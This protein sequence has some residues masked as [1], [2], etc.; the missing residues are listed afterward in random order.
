V[1]DRGFE[2]PPD[3]SLKAAKRSLAG[4]Q[5]GA[6]HYSNSPVLALS[7]APST[8]ID[9]PSEDRDSTTTCTLVELIELWPSLNA[10]N[11]QALLD[12]AHALASTRQAPPDTASVIQN[13]QPIVPAKQRGKSKV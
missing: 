4:A 5:S 9:Q 3:P 8:L 10:D 2:L 13:D 1:E 7:N 6:V 12:H 11:Q